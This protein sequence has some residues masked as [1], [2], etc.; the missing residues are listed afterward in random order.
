MITGLIKFELKKN[1]KDKGL[2]FWMLILPIVFIVLFGFIFDNQGTEITFE[3]PYVNE[4]QSE[5][6]EQFIQA[7]GVSDS[8]QLEEQESLATA[9]A[10][11]EAGDIST[12][13]YL[14]DGFE[15]QLIIGANNPI[16]FHYNPINEDS[17]SPIRALI[18]NVSYSF[19]EQQLRA[20]LEEVGVD[21]DAALTPAIEIVEE[22]V[23]VDDGYDAI[24]HIIP[25]YTVMFTFYIMISMAISF[26]KDLNSG[27]V[28]RLTS[29]PLTKYQYLIGK[30]VPYIL[31]VLAQI[32]ALLTFGYFVYNV[33]LGNLLAIT[34]LAIALAMITTSWGMTLSVL[35]KNE[36]MGIGITQIIALGGAMI[37]GLWMPT[38]FLPR[39]IQRLG[40]FLPQYWAQDGFLEIMIYGG[41]LADVLLNILILL[42]YALLGFLI[43]VL[44]Y[45]RFIAAARG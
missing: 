28:A 8:F 38:E 34:V 3:I 29:T 26:V 16:Y 22:Y 31:I 11:L 12:V 25:G 33:N 5:L 35:T 14:P 17:I 36:N 18:E 2:V 24:S 21:A 6:S 39:F 19:Q 10:D 7:L 40:L 15:E 43:A 9:I 4:D 20:T 45:R 37:G 32:T 27:L 44:S 13:L 42:L 1:L 41:N 23:A 30:W